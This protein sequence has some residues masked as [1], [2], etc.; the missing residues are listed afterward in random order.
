MTDQQLM[1][2]LVSDGTT[3][4]TRESVGID[5]LS[6]AALTTY[7]TDIVLDGAGP[8]SLDD[9]GHIVFDNRTVPAIIHFNGPKSQKAAQMRYARAH[10]PLVK[11]P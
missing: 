1:C 7:Q 4:W 5:H 9:K 6:E 3:I 10:F 2:F 11:G 8:L